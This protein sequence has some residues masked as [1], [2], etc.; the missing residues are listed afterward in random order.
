MVEI[1]QT[2]PLRLKEQGRQ[3]LCDALQRQVMWLKEQRK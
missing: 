1:T 2:L 3:R